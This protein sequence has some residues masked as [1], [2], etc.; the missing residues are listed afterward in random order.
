MSSNPTDELILVNPTA[1]TTSTTSTFNPCYL[2]PCQIRSNAFTTLPSSIFPLHRRIRHVPLSD[3]DL[4]V[5]RITAG[6]S[7]EVVG[8]PDDSR[9]PAWEAV[10]P[11]GSINPGNASAP[12][13][14]F[15]FYVGGPNFDGADA[16]PKSCFEYAKEVLFSYAVYF[17]PGFD[18]NRGGKLPGLYGGAT[19]EVAYGCSGGRKTDREKAFSL[20]LMWRR[21]G[22]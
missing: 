10:Y 3:D 4:S 22:G 20:R 11:K 5:T 2:F 15:G 21:N 19:P 17:E 6:T 18:F 9:V 14:G 7:R 13:G 1:I 12:R 16:A 8:S